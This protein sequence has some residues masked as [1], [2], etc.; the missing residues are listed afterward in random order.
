MP[1]HES[2]CGSGGVRGAG[3][4]QEGHGAEWT[5]VR[6]QHCR[7]QHSEPVT[8]TL[9]APCGQHSHHTQHTQHD[10]DRDG[11]NVRA[12]GDQVRDQLRAGVRSRSRVC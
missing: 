7:E 10:A 5:P 9:R 12:G 2:S 11:D 8:L 1:G 4:S 3:Q 6:S